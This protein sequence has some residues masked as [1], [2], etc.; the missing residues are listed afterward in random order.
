MFK[1][2]LNDESGQGMVEY[3]LIV[4]LI[5]VIVIAVVK[6]FGEQIKALFSDS[7]DKITDETSVAPSN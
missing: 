4:A 1:R 3:A 6:T 5:A 7:T 2:F